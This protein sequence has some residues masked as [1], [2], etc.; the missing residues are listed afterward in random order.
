MNFKKLLACTSALTLSLNILSP[1]TNATVAS[2]TAI[3][4]ADTDDRQL[5]S[6][7]VITL[8][9][10]QLNTELQTRLRTTH[11]D[12]FEPLFIGLHSWD[13][14]ISLPEGSTNITPDVVRMSICRLVASLYRDRR[15]TMANILHSDGPVDQ[16]LPYDLDDR[17]VFVMQ[18]NNIFQQMA[19][20]RRE[21]FLNI[22]AHNRDNALTDE[23]QNFFT[24]LYTTFSRLNELFDVHF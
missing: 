1:A 15:S 18:A 24:F 12:F 6:E 3:V 22:L 19:P 9:H 2:S 11:G 20:E 14:N 16:V 8:L 10:T 21:V 4:D 5:Q 17:M 13:R 23:T 7:D